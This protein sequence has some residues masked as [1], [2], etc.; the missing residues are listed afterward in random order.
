MEIT[1]VVSYASHDHVSQV[2]IG[3]LLSNRCTC[4][5]LVQTFI[6]RGQKLNCKGRSPTLHAK[7]CCFEAAN[8]KTNHIQKMLLW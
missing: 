3:P 8:L 1:F 5:N 6:T 2:D 4:S 7:K